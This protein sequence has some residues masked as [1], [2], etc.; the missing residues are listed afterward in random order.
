M[1]V[2]V[3]NDSGWISHGMDSG[4]PSVFGISTIFGGINSEVRV[5]YK[6]GL[7]SSK[8]SRR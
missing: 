6:H 1:F 8:V 2:F 4:K 5:G 7:E 3:L